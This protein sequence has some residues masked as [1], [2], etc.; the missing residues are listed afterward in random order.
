MN[1]LKT[2]HSIASCAVFPQH[3]TVKTIANEM[4]V[5][6]Y[7]FIDLFVVYL[8]TLSVAQ[9]IVHSVDDMTTN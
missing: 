8:T 4:F 1:N 3:Q 9:T 2:M 5:S 7:V 6:L